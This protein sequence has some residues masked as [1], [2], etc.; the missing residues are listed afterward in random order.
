MHAYN[1]VQQIVSHV[2]L[3]GILVS[4]NIYKLKYL[5]D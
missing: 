2:S 1:W 4:G 5:L 3:L